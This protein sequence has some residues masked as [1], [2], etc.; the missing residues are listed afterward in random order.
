VVSGAHLAMAHA[1][2]QR[3]DDANTVTPEVNAQRDPRRH[4]Q[5]DDEGQVGR[6][7]PTRIELPFL[8]PP[9]TAGMRMLCPRLEIGNNSATPWR[10]PMAPGFQPSQMGTHDDDSCEECAARISSNTGMSETTTTTATIGNKYLSMLGMREPST[11]PAVMIPTD[12]KR[13]PIIWADTKLRWGIRTMPDER[14]K[15]GDDYGLGRAILL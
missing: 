9:T 1:R 7:G 3:A 5:S 11:Y 13:P 10:P 4:V 15:A 12:H 6:L 2:E 14:Y 8:R